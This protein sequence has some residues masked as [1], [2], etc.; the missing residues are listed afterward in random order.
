MEASDAPDSK[1][2]KAWSRPG[3]RFTDDMAFLGMSQRVM[4]CYKSLERGRPHVRTPGIEPG[5]I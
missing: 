2:V 3:P 5:T 1:L 4:S